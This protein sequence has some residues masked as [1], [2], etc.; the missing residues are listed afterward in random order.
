MSKQTPH[1]KQPM[2]KQRSV[3]ENP[4]SVSKKTSGGGGGGGGVCV[5]LNQFY[6]RETSPL[7]LMQ[8]LGV[9][10]YHGESTCNQNI[11]M[12]QK[13]KGLNCDLKPEHKKI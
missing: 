8:L 10:E 6:A 12:K 3:T 13:Q 9:L 2:L 5:C 7:S 11:V 1:L 4:L